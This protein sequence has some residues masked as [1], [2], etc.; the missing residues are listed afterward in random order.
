MRRSGL[1]IILTAMIAAAGAQ[2]QRGGIPG[3][4]AEEQQF[5]FYEAINLADTTRGEARVDILYRLDKDFLIPV[6]NA[7]ASLPYNFARRGEILIELL[8]SLGVSKAR[9]INRIELG[10]NT[11]ERNPNGKSWYQSIVSFHVAPGLYT[12]VFEVDDLESERKHVDRKQKIRVESFNARPLE[13]SGV[14]FLQRPADGDRSALLVPQNF[15]GNLQFG[16]GSALYVQLLGS[17]LSS[18]PLTVRYS[19][20]TVA[21]SFQKEAV[22]I[23]DTSYPVTP[24][25]GALSA[26]SSDGIIGYT[27]GDSGE[28]KIQGLLISLAI[29][30]VPLRACELALSIHQGKNKVE[31]KKPFRMLWPDMPFSLRDVDYA[32]NALRYITSEKE[33]DSLRRGSPE[34]RLRNLENFWKAKDKTPSTAFNEIMA[35]YYRRVDHAIRSFGMLRETDGS[36]TDRGRIYILYGPPTRTE[37]T[38]SPTDAYQE[39]W[40]Y[41]S[42]RKRF[43]FVDQ[44]KTGNYVLAST[45]DL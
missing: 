22:T 9:D 17:E 18:E 20:S 25:G 11:P 40:T 12:I 13:L 41:E 23:I 5:L 37:R 34:E 38:L 2:P 44:R 1:L 36:R 15:G 32:L 10:A 35:E 28:G 42:I 4:Q 30:Q 21:S 43:I 7:E 39:A 29:E 19:L 24:V 3:G 31:L 45:Q 8:D 6:R 26:S 33:V 27:L 16:E 14:V